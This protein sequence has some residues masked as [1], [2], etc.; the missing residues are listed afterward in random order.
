[1]FLLDDKAITVDIS[2]TNIAEKTMDRGEVRV[3]DTY[4]VKLEETQYKTPKGQ[5]RIRYKIL[6]VIDFIRGNKI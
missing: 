5:Y 4:K 1:G 3:G 6:E 2:E